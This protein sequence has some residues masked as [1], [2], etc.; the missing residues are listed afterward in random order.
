MKR[1]KKGF[2]LIELL[3]VIAI[4][5]LLM[6]IL[7]PALA[8]VKK[9]AKTVM[10][11]INLRQWGAVFSMYTNDNDGSFASYIV[12]ITA[13]S[14]WWMNVTHPYYQ[15]EKILL[16]PN[17]TKPQYTKDGHDTGA[18]GDRKTMAWGWFGEM[19]NNR[20]WPG[21]PVVGPKMGSY[22]INAW[23]TDVGAPGSQSWQTLSGWG[24]DP[25][26]CWTKIDVKGGDQIPILLAD[27]FIDRW[28]EHT[29]EPPEYDGDV[30]GGSMPHYCLNR[31]N[32]YVNSAFFDL[33]ARPVGLKELWRLKWHRQF[34]TEGAFT[35]EGGMTPDQ[36]PDWMKKFK[37]YGKEPGSSGRGGRGS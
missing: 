5:A 24:L 37:N 3:V 26:K 23:Q 31:H 16:C 19:Q 10:C 8:K 17:A 14:G 2:T 25:T 36:W 22:G 33:S 35:A 1:S 13:H 12:D 9:Q 34:D 4:I 28:A 32:G 30:S 20:T 15:N 21:S 11:L 6:S 27:D 18:Y 7:M 29:D